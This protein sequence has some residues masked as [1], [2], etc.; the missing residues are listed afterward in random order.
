MSVFDWFKRRPSTSE[1]S[2]SCCSHNAADTDTATLVEDRPETPA[3]A[4][5]EAEPAAAEA[6]VTTP[7]P[8][9]PGDAAAEPVAEGESEEKEQDMGVFENLK[10]KA[11]DLLGQHG[12][13][14]DKGVDK[15]AEVA[16]RKTG[17]KHTDKIRDASDKTKEALGKAGEPSD[18]PAETPPPAAQPP[19][20]PTV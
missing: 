1:E 15:A 11:G 3:D 4:V 6:A 8:R 13:K 9:A 7:A 14:A 2:G 5:T 12:D 18:A 17:G 20:E 19:A 16:D 10:T